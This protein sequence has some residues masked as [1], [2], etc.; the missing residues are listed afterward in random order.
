M[1]KVYLVRHAQSQSNVNVYELHKT[2]NP[3]IE[4]TATGIEQAQ[5]AGQYLSQN[6]FDKAVVWNSPYMRTRQTAKI[7][8]ETMKK[9]LSIEER[10]SIYLSERQFGLVD[11]VVDYRHNY[12]DAINHYKMHTA[13]K[14]DFFVRPPLGESP[15]DM[16]IRLDTFM[17]FEI[18]TS[19][20]DL[21]VLVSHGAAIRGILMMTL[22]W[23]FEK[24]GDEPNPLNASARLITFDNNKWQDHGYVFKPEERTMNSEL[25]KAQAG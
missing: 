17:K 19:P 7:I 10:E 15:F 13:S 6:D 25:L 14:T 18:Q 4:L 21:H 22:G 11:D 23:P 5:Q 2:P 8:K 16:A 20:E 12:K 24:Y 9:S 1:K 3:S